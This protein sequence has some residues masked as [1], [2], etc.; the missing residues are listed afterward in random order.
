V[1]PGFLVY[2]WASLE[3]ALA[4]ERLIETKLTAGRERDAR[5]HRRPSVV[6]PNATSF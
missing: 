4:R 2:A 1:S 5:D 3:R 6:A